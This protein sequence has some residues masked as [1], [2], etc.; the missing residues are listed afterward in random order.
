MTQIDEIATPQESKKFVRIFLVVS[1]IWLIIGVTFQI[2]SPTQIPAFIQ[3]FLF[4][5]L[6]IVFLMLLFWTLFFTEPAQRTHRNNKIRILLFGFFKLV[7]LAFLAI[8][9]KRL[10]NASVS[11]HIM[12][13]A[14]IGIGPLIA[15]V[16]TKYLS[17]VR[18]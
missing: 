3:I 10:R 15:G 14:I 8:T 7:C 16:F 6:D 18:K 2:N 12:G 13:V 1:L 4:S 17:A 11:T 5:F 9:L